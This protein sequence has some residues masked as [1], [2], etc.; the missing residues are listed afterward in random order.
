MLFISHRGN[1]NGPIPERE[2]S[3]QYIDE[4]LAAGFH[5][6]VDVFVDS[7]G[8]IWLGNKS[9]VLQWSVP[10]GWLQDRAEHLLLHLK[11]TEATNLFSST[12][13]SWHFFCNEKDPYSLTSKGYILYWSRNVK[14]DTVN[15][16]CLL[17]FIEKETL[18][19]YS[20]LIPSAGGVISDYIKPLK[21]LNDINLA[22]R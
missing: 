16:Y 2:N 6:E 13:T 5:V 20:R 4:A 19:K 10:Y 8:K 15:K 1:L 7:S 12:Y 21:E 3:P 9:A 17:P 22:S 14:K 18:W 11:N